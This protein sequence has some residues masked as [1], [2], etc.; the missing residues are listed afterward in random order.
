MLETMRIQTSYTSAH[1]MYCQNLERALGAGA[2]A[3]Y[4]SVLKVASSPRHL[5][6]VDLLSPAI[7]SHTMLGTE[8]QSVCW[9]LRYPKCFDLF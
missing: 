1:Y 9:T 8:T 6:S 4:G 7:V 2:P 5:R 3:D